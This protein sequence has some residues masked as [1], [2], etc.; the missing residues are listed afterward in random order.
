MIGN[1]QEC[2]IRLDEFASMRHAEL[3][4]K[5][6][7]G[8][9]IVALG[10]NAM[11]QD[12]EHTPVCRL[13]AGT[14]ITMGRT[15]LIA[16]SPRTA[17]LRAFC[18]RLLGWEP[19]AQPSV[20]SAVRATRLATAKRAVLVI[21][22][23]NDV[24]FIV[25]EIH[26]RAVGSAVPL[27]LC[28]PGREVSPRLRDRNL[29]RLSCSRSG[30]AALGAGVQGTV[31]FYSWSLPPDFGVA[32]SRLERRAVRPI[33]ILAVSHASGARRIDTLMSRFQGYGICT[34]SLPSLVTRCFEV[35]RVVQAYAEDAISRLGAPTAAFSEADRQWVTRHAARSYQEIREATLRLVA[36]NAVSA[37]SSTMTRPAIIAGAAA[38][39]KRSSSTLDTWVRRV[40]LSF[41]KPAG[42]RD[43]ANRLESG[44]C[45]PPT[46]MPTQES[47]P[48][49][50]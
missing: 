36:L 3:A 46:P 15:T 31:C 24:G 23:T 35:P 43:A 29:Q 7:L 12:G 32:L 37:T 50:G 20:E 2:A 1:A 11:W 18:K 34:I 14:E 30:V 19:S 27:V 42:E 47:G 44:A 33:L 9:C 38:M 25:Q 21:K 10:N 8:W 16:E 48:W 26:R 49:I 22:A 41:G 40:Q 6:G 5:D 39:L 17:E 45:N 28:D 4:Y 13:H